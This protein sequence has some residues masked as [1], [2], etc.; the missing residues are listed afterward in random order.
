M[1]ALSFSRTLEFSGA[2]DWHRLENQL[3]DLLAHAQGKNR[4]GVLQSFVFPDSMNE[5]EIYRFNE[6]L[7]EVYL[8]LNLPILGGDTSR[9]GVLTLSWIL[10]CT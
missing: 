4:I 7:N 6:K 8:R 9:G 10:Y 5:D 3:S 1:S 2:V